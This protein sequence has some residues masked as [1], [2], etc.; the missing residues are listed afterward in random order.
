MES[1]DDDE[2][3]SRAGKRAKLEAT[4]SHTDV[5]AVSSSFNSNNS[6]SCWAEVEPLVVGTYCMEPLNA[7]MK[8]RLILRY[9][10]PMG[11]YQEVGLGVWVGLRG[12]SGFGV[13]W[14]GLG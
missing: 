13:K 1:D 10:Q 5:A 11:E 8:Q 4:N 6:N 12:L 14:M 9:L 3:E 7:Q 2:E